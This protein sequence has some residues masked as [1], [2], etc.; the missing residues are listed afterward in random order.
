MSNETIM[1]AAKMQRGD[2]QLQRRVQ[3]AC[4]PAAIQQHQP[5]PF[6]ILQPAAVAEMRHQQRASGRRPHLIVSN[7]DL[8]GAAATPLVPHHHSRPPGAGK[9]GVIRFARDLCGRSAQGLRQPVCRSGHLSGGSWEQAG[10]GG[11]GR[12]RRHARTAP[13]GN[14]TALVR[15][16]KVLRSP[17]I[18]AGSGNK[19]LARC[20]SIQRPELTSTRVPSSNFISEALSVGHTGP[21]AS[22]P[23]DGVWR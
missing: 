6:I 14:K 11:G 13:P 4:R 9:P 7:G 21:Q 20:E 23:Q 8:A 3:A 12:R 19:P 17:C 18:A 10:G 5:A 2:R 16:H 1:K 15:A 22:S